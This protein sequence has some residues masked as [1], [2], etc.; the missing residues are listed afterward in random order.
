MTA[1]PW[2]RVTT[3]ALD[4]AIGDFVGEHPADVTIRALECAH[5]QSPR[6]V[7]AISMAWFGLDTV[8]FLVFPAPRRGLIVVAQNA[9]RER[10][11]MQIPGDGRRLR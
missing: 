10:M 8:R 5:M 2:T 3:L 7:D 6:F 11:M 9:G 1:A 4:A